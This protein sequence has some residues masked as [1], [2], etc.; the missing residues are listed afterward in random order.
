MEHKA[1]ITF[2][3]LTTKRLVLRELSDHDVQEIFLLR[4]DPVVNKYLG[5]QQIKT[6]K[7]AFGFIKM[8]KNSSRSYWAITIKGNEKLIGTI[9]LFDISKELSSCEMGY[10][11]LIEYQ[12]K[13]VM[14]EATQKIIEYSVQTLGLKAFDAYTHKDNQRS[15]NL[16]EKLKFIKVNSV[17]NVDSN[18]I[19][20]RLDTASKSYKE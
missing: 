9:C 13:G 15:T 1:L 20:Y 16:L 14:S 6:Y 4:S 17:N 18:L 10:E 2:P 19:L 11:L 8:I 12:G 7:D 3:I 5:R